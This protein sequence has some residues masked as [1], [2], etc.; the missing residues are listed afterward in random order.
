[1]SLTI[2]VP[3]GGTYMLR[4]VLRLQLYWDFRELHTVE[5]HDFACFGIKSR[6][7]QVADF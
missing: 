4:I 6:R 1:M 3:Q 2:Y 7:I 5:Q